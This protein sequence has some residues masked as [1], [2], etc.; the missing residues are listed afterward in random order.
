LQALRSNITGYYNTA[1]GQEALHDNIDN[2]NTAVGFQA[3]LTN[4]TGYQ[5][6][7]LGAQS[8]VNNT[9]GSY[10][11]AIGYN[12]GPNSTNYSNTTC[13]G[14]DAAATGSNMVR[15]GNVYVGS[16][17]GYQNWTSYSD[18]R[19]KE[20]V[21]EDVPG[22]SFVMKL[23]PVTYT[24][25]V[26]NINQSLGIKESAIHSSV[27]GSQAA[28][29]TVHSGFIA[30]EVEKAAKDIGYD[31]SGVDAPKNDNDMYGLRYAEFVIPLVKAVQ[32]LNKKNEELENRN[33]E[34]LKRI[35]KLE[36]K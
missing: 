32:E 22:L 27:Q 13:L 18:G 21:K 24:L 36:A 2:N 25:D 10:N 30:Q 14:I 29:G 11:T 20:N 35:E 3:S 5:N 7:S 17:G 31:F 6:T 15:I 26:D 23:R 34:L 33:E 4:T 16:I 28:S 12:T 19:F 9:S 8:L 1:I